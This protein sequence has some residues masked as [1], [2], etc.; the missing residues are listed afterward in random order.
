[1]YNKHVNGDDEV[2]TS[3]DNTVDTSRLELLLR[4]HFA[5]TDRQIAE[6]KAISAQMKADNA[7]FH[8]L[9]LKEFHDFAE[10]QEAK[11]DAFA[12]KQEAKFDA[13]T[14]K[15]EAKFDAFTEKIEKKFE[16]VDKKFDT[17]QLQVADLQIATE[18]LRHDV[19]GLYHWDYWL[20]S[21][22]IAAIAMPHILEGIKQLVGTLFDGIS[23]ILG[24]FRSKNKS[25]Q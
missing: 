6:M 12:E 18:G 21:L 1:M 11:F 9:I 10:K 7:E 24:T 5:Q 2:M 20:L 23:G 13:F 16:A 3:G 22:I 17:V 19:A 8:A 15:Q 14:E 25:P 4:E